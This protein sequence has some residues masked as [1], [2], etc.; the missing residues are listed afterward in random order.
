MPT[1]GDLTTQTQRT[2][3]LSEPIKSKPHQCEERSWQDSTDPGQWASPPRQGLWLGSN[4]QPGV[5]YSCLAE[6]VQAG[7]PLQRFPPWPLDI[8]H[9]PCG[10]EPAG[11]SVHRCRQPRVD[12]PSDDPVVHRVTKRIIASSRVS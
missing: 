1:R 10:D 8:G 9:R 5:V 6:D 2:D 12:Q 3:R 11:I 7:Q 4:M